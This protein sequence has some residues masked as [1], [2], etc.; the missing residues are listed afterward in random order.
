MIDSRCPLYKPP[1]HFTGLSTCH[2]LLVYLIIPSGRVVS[3][4][5]T[6]FRHEQSTP[7]L[8]FSMTHSRCV[9]PWKML[10]DSSR[11]LALS[12]HG[13]AKEGE[14]DAAA[15]ETALLEAAEAMGGATASAK[16]C[17]WVGNS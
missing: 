12:H 1:P 3:G 14:G 10:A 8:P 11:A 15:S 13:L 9:L 17:R 2:F 5:A 7:A 4:L 16:S 6:Y